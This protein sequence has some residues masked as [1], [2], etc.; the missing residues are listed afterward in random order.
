M[1]DVTRK[2]LSSKGFKGP[3]NDP[4]KLGLLGIE[5][6]MLVFLKSLSELRAIVSAEGP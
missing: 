5:L 4:D 2:A 3:N 6:L 1:L